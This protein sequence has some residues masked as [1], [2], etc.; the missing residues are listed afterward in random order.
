[1]KNMKMPKYV[2]TEDRDSRT[3][4]PMDDLERTAY[5]NMKKAQ[6]NALK[7]NKAVQA[8]EESIGR[9]LTANERNI[10]EVEGYTPEYYLD[11]KNIIT[12]GVG[13]TG[14]YLNMNFDEVLADKDKELRGYVNN[15]DS[16]TTRLQDALFSNNYRGSLGQS[17]DTRD[18]INA[19]RYDEAATEFLNNKEYKNPKTPAGI[20]ARFE[21][22]AAALREQQLT[23]EM[24]EDVSLY[25]Q[26]MNWTGGLNGVE[27]VEPEQ[28]D[29]YSVQA[30]DID[31][32]GMV[33]QRVGVPLST[34]MELN[35]NIN[36]NV[37]HEGQQIRL[38]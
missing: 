12:K 8:V 22:T 28:P 4:Y 29:V 9:N 16:L 27:D 5:T 15:Y 31:G 33:A 7:G 11:T 38:R 30:T 24:Q 10:V 35:P 34:I 13:Q 26:F 2:E 36:Y 14:S 25:D 23:P 6:K 32:L 17:P 1:M 20:K 37:I 18:L 21:E 19:K 3:F